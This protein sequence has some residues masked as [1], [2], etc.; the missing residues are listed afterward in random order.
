MESG[1]GPGR[2]SNQELR[3]TPN[4]TTT[5]SPHTDLVS[6]SNQPSH[7]THAGQHRLAPCDYADRPSSTSQDSVPSFIVEPTPAASGVP[8]QPSIAFFED[9]FSQVRHL[10]PWVERS[11]QTD[12]LIGM[13]LLACVYQGMPVESAVAVVAHYS[14][15]AKLVDDFLR[16]SFFDAADGGVR[17][18]VGDE[19]ESMRTKEA[20]D[21]IV[22]ERARIAAARVMPP[23]PGGGLGSTPPIA[24]A[25]IAPTP[26]ALQLMTECMRRREQPLQPPAVDGST[27]RSAGDADAAMH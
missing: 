1:F 15:A 5:G 10:V 18:A 23:D 14:S 13:G 11:D 12:N 24:S 19:F 25:C 7:D 9:A 3:N 6:T 20:F 22:A 21:A 4:S 27:V 26:A 2:E 17:A 16:A 8:E